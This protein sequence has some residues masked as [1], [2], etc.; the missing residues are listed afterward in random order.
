MIHPDHLE[1]TEEYIEHISEG[2][3]QPGILRV[4]L[5]NLKN[6]SIWTDM[7]ARAVDWEGGPALQVVFRNVSDRIKLEQKLEK[8]AATDPLTGV[9][10]RRTLH[11]KGQNELIRCRRY[12]SSMAVMMIDVDHFKKINDTMGHFVGDEVL[13]ALVKH[14]LYTLRTTDFFGRLGGEEFVGVL[15]ESDI[16]QARPVA[17]RLR[18]SLG[19]LK[20]PAEPHPV[21]FTVSIGLTANEFGDAFFEEIVHRADQ[22]MYLAKSRGR[23]Q[24]AELEADRED[25]DTGTAPPNQASQ[26][27]KE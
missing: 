13:K 20:V 15:T 6:E 7:V 10:N 9:D 3:K 22:A 8:L 27:P 1:S 17:E 25:Q 18:E 23:N 24:V 2:Q 14:C 19:Q 26:K 4:K 21:S 11:E 16:S 5:I 12:G